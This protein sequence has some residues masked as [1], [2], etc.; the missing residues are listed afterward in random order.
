VAVEGDAAAR[1]AA[2]DDVALSQQL[3]EGAVDDQVA[4]A[5][6]PVIAGYQGVDGSL[7]GQQ[8]SAGRQRG[9]ARRVLLVRHGVGSP[10]A[11]G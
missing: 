1:E 3:D 7:R 11:G 6:L 2:G 8:S 9:E 10:F 5:V 4:L